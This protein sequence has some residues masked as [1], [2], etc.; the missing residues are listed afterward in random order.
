MS[1]CP[2]SA[3]EHLT[4]MTDKPKL[5]PEPKANLKPKPDV[6]SLMQVDPDDPSYTKIVEFYHEDRMVVLETKEMDNVWFPTGG[7]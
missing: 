4:Q 7:S 6:E 2:H 1:L 5:E 3:T